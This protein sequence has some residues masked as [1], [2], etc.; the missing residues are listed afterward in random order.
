MA[1]ALII[2]PPAD[3]GTPPYRYDS[4]A[5]VITIGRGHDNDLVIED[6]NRVISTHHAR[7]EFRGNQYWV[8]DLGSTNGSTLNGHPLAANEPEVFVAGDRVGL[9]T[10]TLHLATEDEAAAAVKKDFGTRIFVP[11]EEAPQPVAA[12]GPDPAVVLRRRV[13][14]LAAALGDATRLRGGDRASALDRI[15]RENLGSIPEEEA[16]AVVA[17]L[18]GEFPDREYARLT[19]EAGE[20]PVEEAPP[21]PPDLGV[22]RDLPSLL[23]RLLHRTDLP[24]DLEW[25]ALAGERLERVVVL[26][27]EGLAALLQGRREFEVAYDASATRFHGLGT[28][29]VKL[30][31]TGQE[32]GAVL[33]YLLDPV[34]CPDADEA[35]AALREA[36]EDC[37]RHQIGLLHGLKRCVR[38]VLSEVEPKRLEKEVAGEEVK[39]GPLALSRK[40]LPGM[41]QTAWRNYVEKYERLATMD[42][43]TFNKLLRPV[44]ARGWL[45]MQDRGDDDAR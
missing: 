4:E 27:L 11:S 13:R 15:L 17:A 38:E 8:T 25:Q 31:A 19:A 9:A 32:A 21:P 44:L 36:T 33:D 26:L 14:R 3:A 20:A 10:Y 41:K 7:V 39:L 40:N 37:L 28:N 18:R 6:R 42:E 12:V 34:E 22:V 35:L 45:E 23:A 5:D 43:A 24:H 2:Q 1:I 29:R 16:S 30:R